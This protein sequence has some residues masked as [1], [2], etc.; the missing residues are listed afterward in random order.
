MTR[1]GMPVNR[2]VNMLKQ[3]ALQY[4]RGGWIR[5]AGFLLVACTMIPIL[6]GLHIGSYFDHE[7]TGAMLGAL[8]GA[9]LAIWIVVRPLWIEADRHPTEDDHDKGA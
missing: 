3:Q 8:V 9:V 1:G 2:G 6:I 7:T 4:G 5:S